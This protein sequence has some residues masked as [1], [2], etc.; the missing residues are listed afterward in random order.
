VAQA[1]NRQTQQAQNGPGVPTYPTQANRGTWS[2][3]PDANQVADS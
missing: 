2:L 1:P 3:S